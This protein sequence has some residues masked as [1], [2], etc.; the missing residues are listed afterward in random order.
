V[1]ESRLYSEHPPRPEYQLTEKG[2]ELRPVLLAMKNWG[3]RYT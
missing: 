2:R 3:E 1:I